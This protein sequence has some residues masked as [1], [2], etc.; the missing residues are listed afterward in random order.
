MAYALH[1][2]LPRVPAQDPAAFQ[3]LAQLQHDYGRHPPA[4]AFA[5][6]QEAIARHFPC[7]STYAPG[8]PAA[9]ECPWSD[10]PLSAN[11]CRDLGILGIA[12]RVEE[13]VTA[14]VPLATQLGITVFDLQSRQVHRPPRCHVRL[15]GVLP[16][17]ELDD[18]AERLAPLFK[19]TEHQCVQLLRRAPLWVKRDLDPVVAERYRTALAAAGAACSLEDERPAGSI[20]LGPQAAPPPEPPAAPVAGAAATTAAPAGPQLE[21]MAPRAQASPD[22]PDPARMARTDPSAADARAAD[23][24]AEERQA[25]RALQRAEQEQA[26]HQLALL[27][28]A[29][30]QRLVLLAILF[31]FLINGVAR[32]MPIASVYLAVAGLA[33]LLLTWRGVVGMAR[34][35]SS[36]GLRIFLTLVP[37]LVSQLLVLSPHPAQSAVM[38]S[39]GLTALGLLAMVVL[40]RAATARLHEAGYQVGL[41]GIKSADLAALAGGA[42]RL[43]GPA[44]CAAVVVVGALLIGISRP[45]PAESARIA[46]SAIPCELVGLWQGPRIGDA[47]MLALVGSGAALVVQPAAA[48]DAQ[49]MAR[50]GV[51]GRR[52]QLDFIRGGAGYPTDAAINGGTGDEL[53][54]IE[55]DGSASH[56]RRVKELPMVGCGTVRP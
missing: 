12:R 33:N 25:A 45:A 39:L 14:L 18:A 48:P 30:G 47:R 46:G 16:G 5:R 27:N 28:L 31:N 42:A 54:L 52:L 19:L 7:L 35:L 11:F 50:W 2:V 38:T 22:G 51:V 41:L 15:D 29:R 26:R 13:V 56:L 23:A 53:V 37:P 9:D 36:P 1:F 55:H 6:L 34:S 4:P 17:L 8:D 49:A 44:W 24:K 40:V 10:G 21:P 32:S 20:Q 3:F 43:N